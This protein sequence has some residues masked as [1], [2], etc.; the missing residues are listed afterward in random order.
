VRTTTIIVLSV[1]L[2]LT[3]HGAFFRSLSPHPSCPMSSD[4]KKGICCRC[5]Q[6]G[7]LVCTLCK[8][9]YY[10]G[11]QCQA[12]D[13]KLGHSIK[14]KEI[15]AA[16]AAAANPAANASNGSVDASG[17]A[18]S[19][20]ASPAPD[21]NGAVLDIS[22]PLPTRWLFPPSK[23]AALMTTPMQYPVLPVGLLNPKRANS[24]FLNVVL[25]C[26]TYTR[27][28]MNLL[29]SVN[30]QPSECKLTTTNKY[31]LLCAV[32][33]HRGVALKHAR[34][35]AGLPEPVESK[36]EGDAVDAAAAAVSSPS[37]TSSSSSSLL[38]PNPK[39]VPKSILPIELL[40]NLDKLSPD[41][42][43]GQQED[44][45]ETIKQLLHFLD[46]AWLKNHAIG[47][48]AGIKQRTLETS[49][50]SQLFGGYLLS[51]LR[52]P[53]ADCKKSTSKF[54]F[55]LDLSLEI[56][57]ATD[58]VTEM[59]EAFT[60]AEKLDSKYICSHCKKPSRARKQ[61]SIYQPPNLLLLQLKRFRLGLF[62][63]INKFVSFPVELSLRK[64][65]SECKIREEEEK[66]A[67][68]TSTSLSSDLSTVYRL[69]AVIVHLD[70][71]NISGFGH[72]VCYIRDPSPP[73]GVK[74]Q[75]LLFDDDTITRVTL[76]DVLK[77]N[78]YVLL[79]E[80][81]VPFV[82]SE[83]VAKEE[84]AAAAPAATASP[85]ADASASSTSADSTTL[86]TDAPPSSSSP[87]PTAAPAPAAA[88]SDEPVQCVTGCGFWG[89]PSTGSMCSSCWRKD[90]EAKG[91]IEKKPEA[92]KPSSGAAAQAAME[93]AMRHL[94]QKQML[95]KIESNPMM[96]MRLRSDPEFRMQYLAIRDECQEFERKQAAVARL[97][98]EQEQAMKQSQLPANPQLEKATSGSKATNAAKSSSNAAAVAAA[99][100]QTLE[101]EPDRT[102]HHG[103][104]K[105][106]RNDKCPCQSGRKFKAC[107][108]KDQ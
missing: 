16:A 101:V 12:K 95:M 54:E 18:P 104:A 24:C 50:M 5:F 29:D 3:C 30:H 9:A 99:V 27:P 85:S 55:F 19:S 49:V 45:F 7:N 96:M 33:K 2:T 51:E 74:D 79:Y 58:Q 67:A 46:E 32:L 41:F 71:M 63:K 98:A 102:V 23:L 34:E 31:C 13:W 17:E 39:G 60:R 64:Y 83:E 68:S 4:P 38:L 48:T 86:S 81:T 107:H 76:K 44:S 37:L 93:P 91:L 25:Q 100:N 66:R 106:G 61:L 94:M 87:A 15:R 28:L 78:A 35:A 80:R 59:L 103:G 88:A 82:A 6:P 56:I 105:I 65:M 62:G 53:N 40:K 73:A 92:P 22:L 52:C 26:L 36:P 69:Y 8:S 14:C 10:C 47:G 11:K 84:P 21:D 70:L 75:W 42:E 89:K 57:E 97:H 20:V 43:L 1:Q 77:L 90:Q 108:G 72:Y